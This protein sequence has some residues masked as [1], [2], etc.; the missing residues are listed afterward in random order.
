MTLRKQIID[1]AAH[2]SLAIIILLPVALLPSIAAFTYAG[3]CLGLIREATEK[4]PILSG[5]S[6]LDILFWTLGGLCVGLLV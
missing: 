4:D 6:L 3:A 2:F 1:Q 5:G